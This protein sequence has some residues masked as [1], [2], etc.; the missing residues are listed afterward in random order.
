MGSDGVKKYRGASV[1]PHLCPLTGDPSHQLA[2]VRSA[3][4]GQATRQSARI[5]WRAGIWTMWRPVD[6]HETATLGCLP[7]HSV[8][9]G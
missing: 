4:F 7:R 1:Q 2:R 6:A 8:L 3:R 9:V 5:H